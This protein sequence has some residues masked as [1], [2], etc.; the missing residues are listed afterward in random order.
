MTPT[1]AGSLGRDAAVERVLS[2]LAADR[3]AWNAADIRG[4]VEQL[5]AAA[6]ILA[7]AAV[8]VELA[9]DLTARAMERCL[10]LL[11]GENMPEHIR[12]WTSR[13]V[14]DVEADLTARLTA[15]APEPDDPELPTVAPRDPGQVGAVAA[16]V[17]D[18][19]LVVV[20]GA[21]GAGKTTTLLTTADVLAA[22]GRRLLVVTPNLKAAQV[23]DAEVGSAAGSAKSTPAT[24]SAR[25][26]RNAGSTSRRPRW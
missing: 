10:P 3:S 4:E 20:E 5:I 17:S 8:R 12:A 1:P 25:S 26:T 9:E 2:T 19:A 15:R 14:L 13:P 7:E 23:A 11:P 22:Q 16:L 6:G 18:R 21:A 24:S